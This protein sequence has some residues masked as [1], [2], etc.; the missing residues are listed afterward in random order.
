[1]YLC[2]L[3]TAMYSAEDVYRYFKD[4]GSVTTDS[5]R[6]RAGSIFFA[7]RG[8]AFDGNDFARDALDKG[9]RFAVVDEASAATDRRFLLVED[10]LGT[11]Q[12]V[13]LLH[14][15][16][17]RAK[18]IAITG[19]NGKTTTKELFYAVLGQEYPTVATQGNLNNHIGV[20]LTLL[21][22]KEDTE[23]AIV[24]MGANHPGE[25]TGLCRLARPDAGIITNIGKAHLEGF[26]GLEGVIRAKSELYHYLRETD[27]MAFINVDDPLLTGLGGGI[28]HFTYG[29]APEAM[30]RGRLV[31][32]DPYLAMQWLADDHSFDIATRLYGT[33]N[34]Y[35]VLAAIAAGVNF[36]VSPEKIVRAVIQYSPENNRSQLIRTGRNTLVMDAYNANP[37]SM[38]ASLADFAALTNLSRVVILGDMLELGPDG[39][40]EHDLVLGSL[41]SAGYEN[42]ILIGPVFQAF[43]QKYPF[44]FFKT[45]D[46]VAEWLRK[47]PLNGKTILLKGSRKIGLERLIGL[48]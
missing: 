1:M 22:I 27:G 45:T 8:E 32:A 42:C 19:S 16:S 13:A 3:T 29:T 17:S 14:R 43:A 34:L 46:E 48:L 35:N 39:P 44:E 28:Q 2:L 24:E 7:L 25:I 47:N 37:S 31:S 38:N 6:V 12:Q 4:C 15:L 26:G 5:R 20:P 11:L 9:A 36:S 23:I 18:V 21:T 40:A 10:A 33:Y 41:V 30:C